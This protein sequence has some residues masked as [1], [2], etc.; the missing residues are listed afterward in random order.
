MKATG[1]PETLVNIYQTKRRI[2]P[3]DADLYHL[4]LIASTS[5]HFLLH[6]Y[7]TTLNCSIRLSR[8]NSCIR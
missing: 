8:A 1:F 4:F 3:E 6:V 5:V 2:I 7:G